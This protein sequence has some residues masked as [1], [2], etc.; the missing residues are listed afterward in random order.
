MLQLIS[1]EINADLNCETKFRLYGESYDPELQ[2]Y[3]ITTDPYEYVSTNTT[4][5]VKKLT[6]N[7]KIIITKVDADTK[8]AIKGVVFELYKDNKKL[9]L[10]RL[11]QMEKLLFQSLMKEI[12]KF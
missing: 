10:L 6:E 8:K 5:Q 7:G 2:D 11:G 9:Q 4:L 3:I 12:I 1:I